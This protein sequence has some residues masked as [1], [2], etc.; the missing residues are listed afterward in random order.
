L[1]C[2]CTVYSLHQCGRVSHLAKK[3]KEKQPGRIGGFVKIPVIKNLEQFFVI[4]VKVDMV[5]FTFHS[6]V[7]TLQT[8]Q[9]LNAAPEK[10]WQF[11]SQPEN[12][13]KLSPS[14]IGFEITSPHVAVM[15][16]GQIITYKIKLMPLVKFNWVTEITHVK[17]GEFF[18]DEQRFGPY[19]MWHHQHL[20]EPLEKGVFMRDVVV[21]KLPYGI[22]GRLAFALFIKKKLQAI[23]KY[24][25]QEVL[26]YLS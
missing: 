8:E 4:L 2:H 3:E 15:H 14:E 5:H 25:A 6:G 21:F 10:V 1:V 9:F 13:N 19:K 18:V 16:P 26:K 7:Y 20:F 24:R 23:F 11:F 22:F 12:L 17:T